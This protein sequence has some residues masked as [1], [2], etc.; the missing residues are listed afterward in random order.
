MSEEFVSRE[1]HKGAS[2]G[3]RKKLEM[4]S[5]LTLDTKLAFLDEIDSGIDVDTLKAI[6]AS[7][8]EFMNRGN[9]SVIVVSHTEKLLQYIKPTHFHVLC[10]G[11]ITASGGKEIM[12]K[13]H[14]CGFCHF[15]RKTS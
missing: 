11:T 10:S 5:L 8:K 9:R 15:S 14:R 6:G 7:I 4:A 1:V 12:K 3:E 2:G 13:I